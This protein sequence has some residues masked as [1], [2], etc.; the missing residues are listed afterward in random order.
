MALAEASLSQH[1][2]RLWLKR[3]LVAL[4]LTGLVAG[5]TVV[6]RT[7][8]SAP[9]QAKRQVAKISILPDTPPPPPPPPREEP[10]RPTPKDEP[11]QVQQQEQPKVQAAPPQD[12]PIKM[13]G[14]AGN[15][16]SMFAA[17]S[18]T[19]DYKGGTP[20]TGPAA[21]AAVAAPTVSDRAAERF[22]ANSARQL[23]RDEIERQLRPE[24]GEITAAFAVWVDAEGRIKRFEL[25]SDGADRGGDL[26][27]ALDGTAR[28]L[29]LPPPGAL[30]QPMRFRLTVRAQG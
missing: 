9:A 2:G 6:A 5:L 14:A 25:A 30:P 20:A 22:Y 18:V 19:Q 24:A 29:K 13:E 12:A 1:T 16:E 10:K 11:K 3:A 15:G 7:L 27:Q 17:G 26:Q 8:L 4:A 21:S 28:A 23:L